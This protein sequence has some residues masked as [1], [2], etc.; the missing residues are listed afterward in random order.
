[1][2][3]E[4][5]LHIL[6]VEDNPTDVFLL[7]KALKEVQSLKIV[8]TQAKRLDEALQHLEDKGLDVVLLD[9]GLPDSQGLET[10]RTM[11]HSHSE[12]PILILSGLEDEKLAV[13]AVK[14]G[15]QDFLVKGKINSMM[16]ARSIRYAI[17]R[18]RSEQRLIASEAGYRRLF[19]TAHDGIF[20]LDASTGQITDVNPYLEELLG[21]T[22][23]DFIGK[24]LWEIAPFRDK[25]ASQAA[26]RTLQEKS[27]I[28]YDDLPLVTKDGHWID[29]E[30]VSNIYVVGRQEVVQCNIRDITHRKQALAAVTEL[31]RF[32]QSTLD[33]LPAHIAVLD[34]T[35]QIVAV[36]KAWQKFSEENG[37][38]AASCGV[39][40][41]YIEVCQ[42]AAGPWAEEGPQVCHGIESV[43]RAQQEAYYLEYPCH[44]PSE[45]RWFCTSVTPFTGGGPSRV[46]VAHE[47]ITARRRSE[48]LVR[49]SEANL[50]KSQQMA[51]LGSWELDL[52]DLEDINANPLHWSD[53]LFRIFGYEPGQLEVSNEAFFHAVHPE[54]RANLSR[55]MAEAVAGGRP[56]SV[57]HRIILPDGSTR[58][59]QSQ[60]E[61]I[62]DEKTGR[63]IKVVGL[64]QDVTERKRAEGEREAKSREIVTIWESMSDAFFTLDTQWRF[65]HI[66]SQ[67]A[68]LWQRNPEELIGQSIWDAFPAAVDSDFGFQY[69]R[70]FEEQV[71]VNFEAW[72]PPE[73]AWREVHV[74]PSSIGLTVYF[75]DVTE[76][77][78]AEAQLHFQKTLLEAQMEASL[79][80]I[81]VVDGGEEKKI[82]SYN[83]RLVQM[84]R[85][86]PAV[87]ASGDDAALREAILSQTADRAEVSKRAAQIYDHPAE[88]T[89][90]EIRLI[91]G[92]IFD[93]YS[94]PINDAN[95]SHFGR[96]WYFRDITKSKQAENTLRASEERF[97]SIVANVP[98]M[99]YQFEMRPDGSVEWPFVGQGFQEIFE[100]DPKILNS[101]PCWPMDQIHLDD[102]TA[103]DASVATSKKMLLPRSW[104]GRLHLASGAIKWIQIT[105][106]PQ[107]LIN[108]GT[109][110]NGLVMDITARKE[111]EEERDRFFTLS[112]D[113]L[114]IV[115]SDG[116]F[117]RIN[118]AWE[119]TLGFSNAEL[120]AAPFLD[121]VH[122]DD[123]AATSAEDTRLGANREAMQ[124][125]NRYRCRDGSYKWLRWMSASFEGLFYCVAHDITAM[126]EAE[127]ALHNANDEL[128]M[129]VRERTAELA[130]ANESLR[131]ENI[132]HQMTMTTL[133]DVAEALQQAKQEADTANLAKS[134][135]LSRMSHELRTPL[136]AIL[137]FGQILD[138]QAGTPSA[139]ESIGYILSG[140]RH[141]LD[142]INEVLDIARVE[143]GHLEL[144]LEPIAL[145]DIVPEACA[146]MRTLGAARGIR[147]KADLTAVSHNYVQ[148]DRQRLKQVLINLLANA[149]K[150]NHEG[151]EVEVLCNSKSDGW[152]SIAVRDSGPGIS[153]QD[154]TKLFTPFERLSASTSAVEGT[155]LGLVLSQRLVTAMGGTLKVESTPG[156]GSTFTVNFPQVDSLEDQVV[157]MPHKSFHE[158][159]G[160]ETGY[161][162][163]VLCIEDN[164]SNLRL[165]ETIFQARPEITL[166]TAIQGS[167][168]LDM[169]RH[170]EPDLILLDLNLPDIHGSEVLTRLQRSSITRDI[171]VV[172][173]SA[174]ATPNQIDRLLSAGAREYLTKPLDVD[175]FL[176]TIDRF[177]V[178]TEKGKFT[179]THGHSYAEPHPHHGQRES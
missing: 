125:E 113:M 126:R 147:L 46:V 6:V 162:Y 157:N 168:G 12:I 128:E 39:G 50:A 22:R 154:L 54:D 98:G 87:A 138:R 88:H 175:R 37:G 124:F 114:A 146:L 155:G 41:N 101:D 20:I 112:L 27:Y 25:D 73:N 69:R 121:W 47:N 48:Q 29:V 75:R 116:Y 44:S 79:D 15:A 133:R 32:L 45:E 93:R 150:Y 170:H 104:E 159:G 145:D 130:T 107:Q 174:D 9:L 99:V 179:N 57:E 2:M 144:S 85:I 68:R 149:I 17:E 76:R 96:V 81:L 40:A 67:A 34:E 86:S 110:W 141:L 18:K 108:D 95:G 115:G 16:L 28:S 106:R 53:E 156:V 165:M 143:A 10:F 56:Y 164:P 127:A 136:N 78:Q 172:V 173:V 33:A 117:K 131:V 176:D 105:S 118:P 177:L 103:F 23:I 123:R 24:R 83:Q 94:A 8:L 36:N 60:A 38:S 64:G 100:R 122:P 152:T 151:G 74:Y 66:N 70:A 129:H 169:A 1:M 91:D 158:S 161:T 82:L 71:V 61:I 139:K 19:E 80:G 14:D 178:V 111:A 119:T 65:T 43:L 72:Y 55:I 63:P 132:Q 42:K 166:L 135:F 26:F 35:G 148:A 102:R 140:G 49:T 167:I 120:M 58:V 31:Q 142:L 51:H 97:Q 134:E 163:S 5:S 30:F 13:H 92:Q 137:G 59:I 4:Q 109:L 90:E 7:K 21:Y 160:Q 3:D 11:Q 171:P 89:H 62:Y 52:S 77:K 84:W 153:P